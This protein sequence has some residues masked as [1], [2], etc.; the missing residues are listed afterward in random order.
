MSDELPRHK[1]YDFS[2]VLA[3]VPELTSDVENALFEAGCDDA[4]LSVSYGRVCME[5]SRSAPSLKAAILSAIRDIRS[6]GIGADALQVDACHLVTQAEIARRIGRSR[7]LIHQFIGGKRGPGGFPPP[8]CHLHSETP[9]WEW[10][11][12]SHWLCSNDM[13]RPQELADAETV[14]A[15]KSALERIHQRKRNPELVDEIDRAVAV[16]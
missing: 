16:G 7:Q 1:E 5:F 2:L 11:S 6:A 15:V 8:A 4:T 12:V 13:I 3:D 14:A 9:L 10:C